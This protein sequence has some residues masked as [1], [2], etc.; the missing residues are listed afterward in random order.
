[1]VKHHGKKA[2]NLDIPVDLYTMYAKLCVDLDIT[3][4]EGIIQYL[5]YLQA[6]YYKHRQVLNEDSRPDFKLDTG[7]PK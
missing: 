1:M 6:Q 7:K 3:K 5:R 2:L 4:T